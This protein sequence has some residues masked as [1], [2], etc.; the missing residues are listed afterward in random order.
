M[1]CRILSWRWS[2]PGGLR[3]MCPPDMIFLA[4]DGGFRKQKNSQNKSWKTSTSVITL[5]NVG[6]HLSKRKAHT[7]FGYPKQK[8]TKLLKMA[9]E[10][11]DFPIK[12]G[13]IFHSHVKLPLNHHF[14]RRFQEISP[15]QKFSRHQLLPPWWLDAMRCCYYWHP[16]AAPS[17]LRWHGESGHRHTAA[18]MEVWWKCAVL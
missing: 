18:W 1:T 9:I 14:S 13:W 7:Q 4:Q 15:E 2:Q 11:V 16:G 12:H 10:I 17:S 3:G 8:Q 6:F 5:P